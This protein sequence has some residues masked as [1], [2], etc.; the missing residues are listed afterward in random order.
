MVATTESG[1]NRQ[2]LNYAKE[3]VK[4]GV[5]N[6]GS[7]VFRFMRYKSDS[8]LQTTD[9]KASEEIRADRQ[10]TNVVRTG[11]N[12]NGD[13]VCELSKDASFEELMESSLEDAFPSVITPEDNV[14]TTTAPDKINRAAGDFTTNTSVGD[15]V[16][17]YGTGMNAANRR[18]YRVKSLTSTE[19]TVDSQEIVTDAVAAAG[20]TFVSG[21]S[22]GGKATAAGTA[23]DSYSFER[24]FTDL[25]NEFALYIGC[26]IGGFTIESDVDGF[27]TITFHI[28]GRKEFE[29]NAAT[30]T[31]GDGRPTSKQDGG[32]IIA[33]GTARQ[34]NVV[35]DMKAFVENDTEYD[36]TTIMIDVKNNHYPN[37]VQGNVGPRSMGSGT[38]VV[39]GKVQMLFADSTQVDKHL[40][41][42]TT[43]VAYFLSNGTAGDAYVI[44][45][46]SCQF[47]AG[48]TVAG[49]QS[50]GTIVEL[51]FEAQQEAT[52]L[53]GEAQRSAIRIWKFL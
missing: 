47:S 46:P 48:D 29:G 51:P 26:T 44:E 30:D 28:L 34:F 3:D 38:C 19:I 49:G 36:I 9:T 14:V 15:M 39:T 12:V 40:A 27:V 45:V 33:A 11:V 16:L 6:L 21:V 13:V 1:T 52:A 8:L 42:T 22:I 18:P 2:T 23:I 20:K 5:P 7:N 41:Y 17:L 43:R 25:T 37:K 10:I 53:S 24:A 32:T 50:Q 31:P 35:D 4:Y